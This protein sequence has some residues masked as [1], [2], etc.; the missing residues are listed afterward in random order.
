MKVKKPS[1]CESAL[2]SLP[3]AVLVAVSG[4]VDSTAL[5]QALVRTGRRPVVLHFDHD[6][7]GSSRSTRDAVEA[8]AKKFGL[9]CVTAQMKAGARRHHETTARRERY[10]FFSRVARRL[11]IID[12]VLAH[13]ADD[14]VETFLLQLLRGSGS[15]SGGMETRAER[16]GLVL[17]RPWLGLWKKEIVAYA[18]QQGLRWREDT[19][20]HDSRH[21][22][23]VVRRR[24]L[25][26]LRRQISPQVPENLLRAAEILRAES[27]WLDS[28]CAEA[29]EKELKT[30]SLRAMPLGRQRRIILRWLQRHAISNIG[31]ADIE[32]VRSLLARPV[33]AKINLGGNRH[34]RR[35]AGVIFIQ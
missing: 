22:R 4:G 8:L 29:N 7:D 1:A 35:R 32:A 28:L 25:P 2:V 31:F 14:Q 26:Y 23:N 15:A 18:R 20:N 9:R 16:D 3:E 34:A 12:L 6:W 30:A 33:P 19:S 21:R 11:K 13:H 27:A 17:H 24:V 5:L 10:A